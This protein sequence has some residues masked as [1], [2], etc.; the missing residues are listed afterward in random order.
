MTESKVPNTDENT[1]QD[2][3]DSGENAIEVTTEATEA[4][5]ATEEILDIVAQEQPELV[6]IIKDNPDAERLFRQH[7]EVMLQVA[8]VSHHQGPLPSPEILKEYNL[9]IPGLGETIVQMALDDA[10]HRRTMDTE[11]LKA[12]KRDNL[13]GQCFGFSIGTIAIIA[14]AI[15]SVMGSQ[16][17]GT[18]L[19]GG[20]VAALVAVFVLGRNPKSKK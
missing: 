7:P 13:L 19:G 12:Q 16:I 1:S 11:I 3:T 5:E 10:Q 20:G 6:E 2:T 14:G 9:A 4:T 8:K 18:V 17:F 15:T